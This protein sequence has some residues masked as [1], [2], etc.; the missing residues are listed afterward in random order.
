MMTLH[1]EIQRRGREEIDR[2]VG[3]E[4]LPSI[5]DRENLPYVNA[6]LKEV[7]RWHPIGPMGLP[8]MT[9]ENDIFH[10][11]LIP[12]GAIILPNIW[13]VSKLF[14]IS[15]SIPRYKNSNPLTLS[16][17]VSH[18]IRICITNRQHLN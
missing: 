12:K 6:I 14:S 11:H 9:T 15:I 16:L 18:M 13:Y 2:V 5:G 4:R 3:N 8:H 17:G 10:G 1:P 7:L